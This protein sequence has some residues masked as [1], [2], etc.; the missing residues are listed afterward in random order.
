MIAKKVTDY[1]SVIK[2]CYSEDPELLEKYHVLAP[3]TLENCSK[4]TYNILEKWCKDFYIVF[5]DT[6]LIGYFGKHTEIDLD[7]LSTIY[8][9]PKFRKKEFMG[10]F[11]KLI[12]NSFDKEFYTGIYK[13]NTRCADFYRKFAKTEKEQMIDGKDALIFKFRG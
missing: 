13:K 4:D 9:R 8:V 12:N 10:N 5:N 2:Q 1:Y 6:E 3:D 7:V 11:W